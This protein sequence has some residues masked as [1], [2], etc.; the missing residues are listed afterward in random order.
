MRLRAVACAR[1]SFLVL[2]TSEHLRGSLDFWRLHP[3]HGWCHEAHSADEAEPV[4][5]T[6]GVSAIWP[7]ASDVCQPRLSLTEDMCKHV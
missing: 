1:G 6:L 5:E 4:G 2:E 3:T 7:D